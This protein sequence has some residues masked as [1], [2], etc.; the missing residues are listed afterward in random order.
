MASV[1]DG[2]NY[3]HREKAVKGPLT[4]LDPAMQV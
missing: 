1:Q 3:R 2:A 4:H